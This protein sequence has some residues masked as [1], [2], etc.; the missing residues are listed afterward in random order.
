MVL[1]LHIHT[2]RCVRLGSQ[3]SSLSLDYIKGMKLRVC[4]AEQATGAGPAPPL[5][6]AS[7]YPH[8]RPRFPSALDRGVGRRHLHHST[9]GF[10]GRAVDDLLNLVA[11]L[12]IVNVNN[13]ILIVNHRAYRKLSPQLGPTTQSKRGTRRAGIMTPHANGGSRS[14]PLLKS[15]LQHL[16]SG[17]VDEIIRAIDA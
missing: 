14:V 5:R 11:R 3:E 4:A 1:C 7:L 6:L 17:E 16:H 15:L 2:T 8:E 12:L 9:A 10:G 13:S